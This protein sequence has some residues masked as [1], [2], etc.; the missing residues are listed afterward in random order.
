MIYKKFFTALCLIIFFA[1]I[2]CVAAEDVNETQM[3]SDSD[4]VIVESSQD[5]VLVEADDGTF[6]SL[7]KK[8]DD[9][10]EG[11]TITLDR[12]YAYDEGFSTRGIKIDKNLTLIKI[13]SIII[14]GKI[15]IIQGINLIEK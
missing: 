2:L 8:I 1:S 13:L 3:L 4:D 7:Q 9:A 12:D 11:S 6:T 10:E 14:N 5:E 15:I